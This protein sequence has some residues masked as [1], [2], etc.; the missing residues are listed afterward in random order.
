MS[1]LYRVGI[2][3]D[4]DIEADNEQEAI[5]KFFELIESEPQQTITS[6][7]EDNIKVSELCPHCEIPLEA[8]MI[9]IDGTNLEEHVVCP[10]CGYGTPA[11]Q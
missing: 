9:D 3:V 8:K 2:E 11:L 4:K 6:F 1:L 7:V 10:D 5:Q